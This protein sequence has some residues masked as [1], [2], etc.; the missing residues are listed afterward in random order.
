[1][2]V[3][4]PEKLSRYMQEHLLRDRVSGGEEEPPAPEPT[5]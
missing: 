4:Q 3:R 1:M 2:F 5:P